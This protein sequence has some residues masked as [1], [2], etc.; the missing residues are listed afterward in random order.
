[1]KNCDKKSGEADGVGCLAIIGLAALS[2]ACGEIWGA[3]IG[4]LVLG[5]SCLLLVTLSIVAGRKI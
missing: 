3:P 2:L 4:W 5:V 1:M